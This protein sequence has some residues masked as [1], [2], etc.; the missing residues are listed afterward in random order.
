MCLSQNC[1][2]YAGIC[3]PRV[4]FISLQYGVSYHHVFL[5]C[6]CA[7]VSNIR[8]FLFYSFSCNDDIAVLASN[9]FLSFLFKNCISQPQRKLKRSSP[10]ECSPKLQSDGLFLLQIIC[11]FP[12]L[13]C[14]CALQVENGL[15]ASI[16]NAGRPLQFLFRN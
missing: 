5:F 8:D 6:S 1:L 16:S 13:S 10:C 15:N 14:S 12:L 11:F 9:T 3:W 2:Y 7:L 4:I